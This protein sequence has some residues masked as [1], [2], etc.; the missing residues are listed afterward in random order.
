MVPRYLWAEL[1]K[2]EFWVKQNNKKI[3]FGRKKE[4]NESRKKRK[5]NRLREKSIGTRREF[6]LEWSS[7]NETQSANDADRPEVQW[8]YR[9]SANIFSEFWASCENRSVPRTVWVA[10]LL[11]LLPSDMGNNIAR[12]HPEKASDYNFV[13]EMLLNRY[14]LIPELLRQFVTRVY[15]FLHQ[16]G[17]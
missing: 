5:L 12:E 17:P 9:R 16:K 13:T 3:K 14:K 7:R 2:N 11:G 6:E 4:K 8:K 1:S 10:Y 15:L